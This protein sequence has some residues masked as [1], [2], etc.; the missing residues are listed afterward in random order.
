MWW[1]TELSGEQKNLSTS[2][3]SLLPM[4]IKRKCCERQRRIWKYPLN[5]AIVFISFK[6]YCTNSVSFQAKLKHY[7]WISDQ[8][9]EHTSKNRRSLIWEREKEVTRNILGLKKVPE[10]FTFHLRTNREL[11]EKKEK[12]PLFWERGQPFMVIWRKRTCRG[13]RTKYSLYRRHGTLRRNR[14][15]LIQVEDG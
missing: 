12:L 6:E 2:V 15:T 8:H 10:G 7:S 4:V 1:L 9:C 5:S 11:Y 13:W 14:C 3:R